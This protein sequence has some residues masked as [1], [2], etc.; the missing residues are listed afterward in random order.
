MACGEADKRIRYAACTSIRLAASYPL[1]VIR[2]FSSL[3]GVL[4]HMGDSCEG[5]AVGGQGRLMAFA[6]LIGFLTS[7][8]FGEQH[9]ANTTSPAPLRVVENRAFEVGERLEYV[10]RLGPIVAGNS[11]LRVA[12]IVQYNG[13]ACYR[14]VNETASNAF[15]SKF[16]RVE[17]RIEALMDA[18]GLFS[19]AYE[20]HQREGKYK[21]DHVVW[22]D[23]VNHLAYT[24]KDT[25][26][27]PPFA[28]DVLSALYYVR[29][30][31]IEVGQTLF[32]DNHDDGKLYPLEIKVHRRE[33]VRTRAGTFTALVAE[34]KLRTGGFFKHKGRIFVWVTDD[35]RKI[36]VK[37][38]S[39]IPVGAVVAELER[40]E[41]V[42]AEH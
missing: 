19:W 24:Q 7:V 27:I 38:E 10:V 23:Q 35:E 16:Y 30:L 12:E 13:A 33:K 22:L 18:R 36:P 5:I 20:K 26:P 34:P 32:I 40:M 39:K 8:G 11:T 14:L 1:E 3:R 29:T 37:L 41:G 4:T 25:T 15:F 2:S 6:G 9:S 31:P 17:D 21:A 42:L 28:Q